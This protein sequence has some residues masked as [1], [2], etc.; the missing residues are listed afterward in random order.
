MGITG[1]KKPSI[2]KV[3]KSVKKIK[4][5]SKLPVCVGFGITSKKSN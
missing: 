2:T 3:E 5:I 1:T 4:K